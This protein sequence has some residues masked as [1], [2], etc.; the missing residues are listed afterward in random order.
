MRLFFFLVSALVVVER[1]NWMEREIVKSY[2]K[3]TLH[4][5]DAC[6]IIIAAVSAAAVSACV[7]IWSKIAYMNLV[8]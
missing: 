7:H 6:V 8:H 5:S 3:K 2:A 1:H 4:D